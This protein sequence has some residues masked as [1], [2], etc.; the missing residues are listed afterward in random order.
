MRIIKQKRQNL[1]AI[2]YE[3]IKE[4]IVNGELKSGDIITE[5]AI[6][7]TLNMS[8]TPV[9]N[10]FAKLEMENY[11]VCIDGIGTMVKGLS[12]KE[13]HDIYDVRKALES[14]ALESGIDNIDKKEL[15]NIKKSLEDMLKKLRNSEKISHKEIGEIDLKFH[16]LIIDSSN[17]HYIKS[18]MDTISSQIQRYRFEAY[19]I[20]DTDE[21]SVSRHL[22]LIKLMEDKN[23]EELENE[24][25]KH[26]DWSF[27][28]VKEAMTRM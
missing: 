24:L 19:V 2:A 15:E 6:G 5:K 20:T 26:I 25:K 12:L 10:A 4:K 21:E 27:E 14:M 17:N 13:L 7:E 11:L 9:K 8:R 28:M 16:N 23:Y 1:S 18:L 3:F 22:N